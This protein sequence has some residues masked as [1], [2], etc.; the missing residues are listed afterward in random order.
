MQIGMEDRECGA[1]IVEKI[2]K[3]E[4]GNGYKFRKKG[5]KGIGRDLEAIERE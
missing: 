3:R 4:W 2:R 1:S 5:G